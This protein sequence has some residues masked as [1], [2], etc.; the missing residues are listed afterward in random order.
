MNDDYFR[1]LHE[2]GYLADCSITPY[3][4]WTASVGQM[5]GFAGPVEKNA[6]VKTEQNQSG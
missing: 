1:I 2:M 5:L 3:V 4:D 6:L